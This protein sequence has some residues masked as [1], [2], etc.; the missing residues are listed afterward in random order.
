VPSGSGTIAVG[1]T[2]TATDINTGDAISLT[3]TVTGT[4]DTSVSWSVDGIA[5]G[6]AEVGTVTGSGT[7]VTYKA[8]DLEGSHVLTA[9]STVDSSKYAKATV[10]I[11]SSN[12]PVSVALSPGASTLKTGASLSFTATVSNSANAAVSWTVDGVAN[13]NSVTG[14]IG[15]SGTTVSYTAPTTPGSHTLM[16]ASV[17]DPTKTASAALTV[18]AQVPVAVTLSP[19]STSLSTGAATSFTATVSGTTNTAVAWS[20]DGVANGNSATGTVSGSGATV[21]YTAPTSAGS[22]TLTATSAADISKSASA[23]I[24]IQA[25]A[26]SVAVTLSPA[27]TSLAAGTG[28]SFTASVT[29]TTNTAVTWTVDG[30]AGGNSTA[31]TVSGSGGTV[32][33]TAPGTAGTHTLVATS[34]ADTTKSA[35]AAITVQAPPPA[36]GVSLNPTA[37]SLQTGGTASFT[38]TVA[39]ATNTAV[40]WT[41]DGV[42]G[43]NSTAGTVSGSGGTVTYTAPATAGT[44]TLVAT[45]AADASKTASSTITVQAPSVVGVTL[46]PSTTSLQASATASFTAAVTNTTNTAV[47]WKVDGVVNGNSTTGTITGSGATVTYTAPAAA[48]L[49]TLVATS[50]ADATKSASSTITVQAPTVVGVTL[51]PSAT[52]LASGGAASFTAAVTNA[53][54]TAVTWTVDGVAGGNSTAGTVTGSGGTITYTA[55]TSAGTHTLVATSAAD[56]S[57]SAAATITVQAPVAIAVSLSPGSTTLAAASTLSF[58]AS[59]SGTT[60]TA[61]TWAVDGVVG[62][63]ATVGTLAASGATAL[64]TAPATAGTHTITATSVADG[65]KVG[66][67]TVTV[68]AA[69]APSGVIVAPNGVAGNPGTLAAPTTL[70]G[71][72]TLIQSASRATPGTLR[73]LLRGG[74]YPRSSTFTLGATDS[75]TTANPVSYEAYPNETPRII[76]GVSISPSAA[77]L[78]DG[79]DPNWSRLD[80][81]ARGQIYVVD[82]TAYKS[83]IGALA[84][85]ADS[86]GGVNQSMEVFVDG[87]PLTLARYPKA[88]DL[89]DANLTPQASIRVSG[90]L[91]PDATGDYAYKGLDSR[92]RPYYQLAKG[93]DIW[94]IAASATAP[95]WRLSN[96]KDLGGTGS[97]AS[98][99]TWDTFGSPAGAFVSGS[100]AS[101]TAFLSPADGSNAVP[102]F[103]LIRSTNGTTQIAAPD[104]NMT[105]WRASEAMYFGLGYYSWSGSHS[106]LTS[107]DPTTGTLVLPASPDYGFRL[108]QPFFVYNLLEELTAPGEYFID[109]T[110]ARLYLR[111]TGDIPPSEILVSILQGPVVQLTSCQQITWQ[112]VTFEAAKDRLVYGT[113]C[114]AVTFKNCQ[115][116]NAGGYG[117]T[118]GG[119]SN[120]VEAC[121]FRYLGKGGVSLSGGNRA[122][123]TPSGSLVQNCEFQ[124][125]GRLFWTYQPGINID[126]NSIGITAQHNEIHHSP[127]AA[128]LFGGNENIMRYNHIHDVT[129]WTNDAGAIYTTG[130]DW[131][132]QGNLIQFNLIRNCGSP[133]GTFQSGI[134]IDGVGSGVR[135]EGNILYRAAPQFAVQHNGGR[136]VL[137]QYNIFYGHWYGVDI[138]NVAFEVVN[139]T[140]GSSWNLLGKLL[141]MNYQSAPWSTAYP[142][143]AAIPNTWAQIQGSQWLE[144]GGSSCYGNLHFG[145]S[146]DVYRQ[147]NSATSLAAPIS[148]F[149][150]TG[151]NLSQ[152]DPLFTDASKLDFRLQPASPM[153][154][155]PGFPGIDASQIGIQR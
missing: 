22:H 111:P 68:Q 154:G 139:N 48:G 152:V 2:P 104:P 58:T 82:L 147:H 9:T 117:L 136:D 16:A 137:T 97:S 140:S 12:R 14:T 28:T 38:A 96:R 42:A 47:T 7:T 84:S 133:L 65:T 144:P 81:A 51:T 113:G 21:T 143:V 125:Y 35:S 50:A 74:L 60:N 27:S 99:G 20:V 107:L 135:V 98:W 88:V 87:L 13:G 46:N 69:A 25:P 32:T 10:R 148:W 71:A 122:T 79:T 40:T 124:R 29:G 92:G 132:M 149:S 57:K 126:S 33:Y 34:A 100:G 64:Y 11:H 49:H 23:T 83:S 128:I 56:T 39:N 94:S 59:V 86:G 45:S 1:V 3:V 146:V 145:S 103:L 127:H 142:N 5:G 30:V 119:T 54:N 53:S 76:G 112:G 134:Y 90:T 75:G 95:D 77:R 114:Q 116:R 67:S 155:I 24:T 17:A 73:V 70:E 18:Q 121:D 101:G 131:G 115:F 150:K 89:A 138:S 37:A 151:S 4:S 108:G 72:R 36:V 153:Y 44:H 106:T 31:G 26:T 63:N 118:L 105:Q 6:N 15:G 102:G 80:P 109:R 66:S 19:A 62:G 55:P 129:Q 130:R 8:P 43:G 123:L 91:S 120:L 110:N 141:S 52:T 61:L 78:V 93:G 85:R 41:V